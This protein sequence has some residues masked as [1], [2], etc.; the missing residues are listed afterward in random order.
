MNLV[1][2]TWRDLAHPSAG[3]SEHYVDDLAR[4]LAERGHAVTLLAGGP[5]GAN[6]YP[7]VDT[8]STFGQYLRVPFIHARRFR[9][10]DLVIDVENGLPYWSPLWRRGPK[11]CLVHHVHTDQWA[12]R[13]PGPVAKVGEILERRLLPLVYRRVPFV[14]VSPSTADA[15]AEIGVARERIRIVP[16]A[17]ADGPEAEAEAEAE[18]PT[19]LVLG[20]LVPHKQVDLALRLWERVRPRTGGRLI[21]V[22]DGPERARLEPMAGPGVHFTGRVDDATK[23]RL[24]GEAWVLIHPAMHEGWGVVI[25]EAGRHRTPA[26]GFAVPGVRDA[27]IDGETGVLA[28]DEEDFV[29]AWTELGTGARR[30]RLGDG[31]HEYSLQFDVDTTV[32]AFEAACTEAIAVQTGAIV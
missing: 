28:T 30:H 25:T 27:I 29:R 15:L 31:A 1:F 32:E 24:L 4:G 10:A 18:E 2:I 12:T 14:A 5:V 22:G 16:N 26:I 11:L 8:G 9:G 13:F 6:P 19:F 17:V 21:I 3:G 23:H 7:T 20:R